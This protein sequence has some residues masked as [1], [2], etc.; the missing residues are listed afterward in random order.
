MT[1]TDLHAALSTMPEEAALIFRTDAGDI[2]PGYHV[3]EFKH[4]R[5]ESI[6]CGGRTS[7]WTEAAMQVL[8]GNGGADQGH[9]AVG[10]FAAI[11]R[12]SLTGVPGLGDHDFHVEFAP[13]NVGMR[14][15]LPAAPELGEGGVT[16]PLLESGA[17]CKP[18]E[19]SRSAGAIEAGSGGSCCGPRAS[20]CC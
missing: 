5:V 8:D 7:A 9:M 13:G 2:S 15:Y 10:K 18:L 16:V 17:I 6:D 3:T 12:K 4:A 19:E 11:L 1:L 20:N 14:T